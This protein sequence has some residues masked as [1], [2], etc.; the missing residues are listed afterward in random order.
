M[1]TTRI[2][3]AGNIMQLTPVVAFAA[4]MLAMGAQS[5]LATSSTWSDTGTNSPSWSDSTN[6][7]GS[8]V[9]GS[10]SGITTDMATFNSAVGTYGTSLNPIVIDQSTQYIGGL[11]FNTGAGSYTIGTTGGKTLY[12]GDGGTTTTSIASGLSGQTETINA[13]ITVESAGYTFSTSSTTSV[14]ALGGKITN[15]GGN[16]YFDGNNSNATANVVSGAISNASST[17]VYGGNWTFSGANGS[18]L[19]SVSITGGATLNVS[20]LNT[21]S[22]SNLG[23]SGN[24]DF[25]TLYGGVSTLNYTGSSAGTISGGPFLQAG[26]G[27]AGSGGIIDNN[28]TGYLTIS[29]ILTAGGSTAGN[30]FTLGGTG[31][32]LFSGGTNGTPN[33]VFTVNGTGVWTVSGTEAWTGTTTVGSGSTTQLGSTLNVTGSLSSSSGL[34]VGAGATFGLGKGGGGSSYKSQTVA[35]IT[36]YSGEAY[37]SGGLGSQ[38]VFSLNVSATGNDSLTSTGAFTLTNSTTFA[39]DLTQTS[40]TTS[41]EQIM[42]WLVAGSNVTSLSQIDL[43]LNGN[44]LGVSSS[45]LILNSSGGEDILDFAPTVVPEP[46]TWALFLGG[47]ALLVFVQRRRFART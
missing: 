5:V 38:P 27:N 41:N 26:I 18:T 21:G 47:L 14:F 15:S 34:V 1:N 43:I 25:G 3:G 46:G 9:P 8:T 19:T 35:S 29:D 23:D 40:T 28:G 30:V 20:T 22:T 17:L 32:G 2:A 7:A 37:T 24:L 39:L 11:I 31:S 33:L 36:A 10:T 45:D 13:P 6:W 42:E 44:N 12:V 4:F 16:L